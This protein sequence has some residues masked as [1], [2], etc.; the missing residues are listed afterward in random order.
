M[1]V[2]KLVLFNLIWINILPLFAQNDSIK[3]KNR[4]SAKGFKLTI[5][6]FNHAEMLGNGMM[7]LKMTENYLELTNIPFLDRRKK[8]I[9][10]SKKL[11]KFEN[12]IIQ[13]S[14]F[15]LDTLKDYYMNQCIVPTSGNEYSIKYKTKNVAKEIGLHH[16]YLKQIDDLIRLV[17][18]NLPSEYQIKYLLSD[19]EQDCE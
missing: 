2:K 16:Y 3:A 6:S 8:R 18:L 15:N 10:F 1:C 14:S 17:N 12:S 5:L 11:S 4:L 9:V 19:T 7:S 13:I